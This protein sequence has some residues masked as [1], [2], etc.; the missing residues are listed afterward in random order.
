MRALFI[1]LL[2]AASS[3][4]ASVLEDTLRATD[5]GRIRFSY[6]TR[7][8]VAG[9]GRSLIVNG[10]RDADW[11]CDCEG[12]PARVQLKV[13]DG[14]VVDVDVRVGGQWRVTNVA[15]NDIGAVDALEAADF[16]IDLAATADGGE[17]EDA[18]LGA[19]IADGFEDHARLLDIVR[20]DDRP[21][22]IRESAI[23][24]LGQAAGK[25]AAAELVKI[26]DD[27]D[28]E[29]SLREHAIFSLS[30]RELDECFEPLRRVATMSRHP[31]LREK[32]FFW[33]AQHDDPRVVELFERVLAN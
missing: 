26:V 16:L 31:Q 21:E 33:L 32:A 30:Q 2:I 9:D 20:D 5:D 7:E 3:A 25:R 29:L 17:V 6:P 4:S 8:G 12:G 10:A 15:L 18:V 27:D 19:V 14:V 28:T 23:F 24:W 11:Q 13:R 1:V 22:P